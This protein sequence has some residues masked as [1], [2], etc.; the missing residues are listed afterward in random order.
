MSKG[1]LTVITGCMFAGKTDTLIYLI[2]KERYRQRDIYCFKPQKDIRYS[3]TKII[4]HNKTEQS[5]IPVNSSIDIDNQLNQIR[6]HQT[7]PI[8]IAIEEI[9]FFDQAIAPLC[10]SLARDG[11]R[12][13]VSGLDLDS[14]G[15]PFGPMPE[16][17]AYADEVI[18]L[19]AQCAICGKDARRSYRKPNAP[20]MVVHIGGIES[21]DP[22][23]I[24]CWKSEI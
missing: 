10:S 3:D 4:S 8:S 13:F 17:L 1:K 9:Q 2:N 23:C 6:Q 18:K 22:R 14:F 19:H 5:A 24:D 11:V 12:V 7:K 21:Y 16:L 20:D 15:H